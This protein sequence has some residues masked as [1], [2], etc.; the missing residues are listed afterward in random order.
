MTGVALVAACSARA[1]ILVATLV[2]AAVTVAKAQVLINEVLPNPDDAHTEEWVELYNAGGAAVDLGG[3]SLSDSNGHG[4]SGSLTI[5]TGT[6]IAPA[7]YLV[8][9]LRTSDGLLNNGGDDVELYDESG[10]LVDEAAW[11]SSV[12]GDLS[13]ARQVWRR[14]DLLLFLGLVGMRWMRF[15]LSNDCFAR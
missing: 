8:F 5:D 6:T 3:W 10:A 12:P 11:S 2:A 9:T 13:M 1:A 14:V 4:S 7:D 15:I